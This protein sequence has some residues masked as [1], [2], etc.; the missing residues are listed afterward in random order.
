VS[1]STTHTRSRTP[2]FP[3]LTASGLPILVEAASRR[4]ES[5]AEATASRD[6]VAAGRVGR[7]IAREKTRASTRLGLVSPFGM[8]F[9]APV[10][11]KSEVSPA[12]D[13]MTG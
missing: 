2:F 10:E 6:K 7:L 13:S 1:S 9:P 11:W 12:D 4:E 5:I 3:P 8:P